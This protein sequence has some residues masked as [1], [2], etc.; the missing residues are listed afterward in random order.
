MYSMTN[1]IINYP[2]IVNWLTKKN[3]EIIDNKI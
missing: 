2:Y 3:T 1:V